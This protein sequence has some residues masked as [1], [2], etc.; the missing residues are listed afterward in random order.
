MPRWRELNDG[1]I[2]YVPA[3]N[4]VASKCISNGY[5]HDFIGPVFI[6]VC[7]GIALLTSKGKD[8]KELIYFFYF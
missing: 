6:Y 7:E 5:C 3:L 8:V 1:K 4:K 2:L